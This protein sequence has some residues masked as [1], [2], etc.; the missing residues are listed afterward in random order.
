MQLMHTPA[1]TIM[2]ATVMDDFA[3][4]FA[5]DDMAAAFEITSIC[6]SHLVPGI[7]YHAGRSCFTLEET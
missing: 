4:A 6:K 5:G 1:Y 7:A 3:A 2:K